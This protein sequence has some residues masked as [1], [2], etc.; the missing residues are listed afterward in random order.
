MLVVDK[1]A[2]WYYISHKSTLTKTLISEVINMQLDI[3]DSSLKVYEALA[4]NVRLNIIQLLSKQKMNIK[5]LATELNLSSPI[6]SKHINKLEESGILKTEK[7]PGKSGIQRISILKVD[8]IE[9]VFPKKIYPS[10]ETYDTSIPIGHYTDY[11]VAPTCGLADSK[12]FIG[13]VDE[14][15]YFM[16]ARRMDA[17]ILWFTSGYVEY[18]TPNFLSPEDKLEQ[19]DITLELSS[20]FPFSNDV[21]PSDITFTL[22]G[23]N[24]G[25]WTSPGDFADTRGKL[26][27][28]WWPNNLN[29]YG[30]LKTLRL[31]KHGTYMDGDMLSEVTTDSFQGNSETWDLRISVKDDAVNVGGLTLFGKKFG[32]HDQD[33]LF[34]VYYS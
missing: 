9:I 31:T 25:T 1:N 11:H 29:Q 19:L 17:S 6:V 10:F 7:V 26:N 30:L 32:N 18:K 28:E 15:K 4:S 34:K 23:I 13:N 5:E 3:T 22:N 27:P 14:P 2:S 12:D 8:N 24:V 33:I 16:D 20:E 21:W